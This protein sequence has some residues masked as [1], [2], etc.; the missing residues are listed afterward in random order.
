MYIFGGS[1]KTYLNLKHNKYLYL[2]SRIKWIHSL[3]GWNLEYLLNWSLLLHLILLPSNRSTRNLQDYGD[4]F[5]SRFS[6]TLEKTP[7]IKR[8]LKYIFM[9]I[10]FYF[11]NFSQKSAERKSPKKYVCFIVRPRIW[12]VAWCLIRPQST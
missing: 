9:A 4:I 3:L 11:Q 5:K 8:L 2:E 1:N 6:W 12:T 10:L 7:P